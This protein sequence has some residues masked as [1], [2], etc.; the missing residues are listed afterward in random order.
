MS[1]LPFD[2]TPYLLWQWWHRDNKKALPTVPA[3]RRAARDVSPSRSA[4]VLTVN[5]SLLLV[6]CYFIFSV[7]S[8]ARY[9]V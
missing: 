2:L 8:I 5:V 6:E 1:G 9:F 4:G 3:R 7:T